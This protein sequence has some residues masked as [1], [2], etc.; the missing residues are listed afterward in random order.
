VT[1]VVATHRLQI[2]DR[3]Q[4]RIFGPQPETINLFRGDFE[5]L[6]Q[7]LID[8]ES[9]GITS[10]DWSRDPYRNMRGPIWPLD[11]VP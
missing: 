2:D 4:F 8:V 10:F 9:G 7:R 1:V 5:K 6:G 3:E 11:D